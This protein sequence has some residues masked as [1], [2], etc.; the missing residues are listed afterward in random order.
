[1][2]RDKFT[3]R[4]YPERN[5]PERNYPESNYPGHNDPEHNYPEHNYLEHYPDISLVNLLRFISPDEAL[6]VRTVDGQVYYKNF[7]SNSDLD[8]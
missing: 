3:E 4:N 1:M 6:T 2:I 8:G 5:Y 7:A